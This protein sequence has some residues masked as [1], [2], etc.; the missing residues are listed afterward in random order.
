M[1]IAALFVLASLLAGCSHPLRRVV[2]VYP[3]NWERHDPR[4][5]TLLAA[6]SDPL[7]KNLPMLDCD[8]TSGDTPRERMLVRDVQFDGNDGES[9]TC[10]LHT[11]TPMTCER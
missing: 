9:W 4:N 11:D 7:N 10:E 5:C 1:K 8:H 3:V 6:G 2:V